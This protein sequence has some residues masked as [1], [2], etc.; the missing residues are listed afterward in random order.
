MNLND[1]WVDSDRFGQKIMNRTFRV[2]LHDTLDRSTAPVNVPCLVFFATHGGFWK[3]NSWLIVSIKGAHLRRG[4]QDDVA[5]S[6]N[7]NQTFSESLFLGKMLLLIKRMKMRGSLM[8]SLHQSRKWSILSS[9]LNASSSTQS[10]Q[11]GDMFLDWGYPHNSTHWES[12]SKICFIY[13]YG[14][15]KK[16]THTTFRLRVCQVGKGREPNWD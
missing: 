2:C 6:G 14:K 10:L 15:T 11:L 9:K 8:L 4:F 5:L 3:F 1:R 16:T 12:S 7:G 13:K